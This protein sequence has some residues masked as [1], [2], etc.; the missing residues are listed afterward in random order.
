MNDNG[1]GYAYEHC[2]RRGRNASVMLSRSTTGVLAAIAL[3]WSCG[4]SDLKAG[5]T[6][7]Q[8][9]SGDVEKAWGLH[10]EDIA[11]RLSALRALRRPLNVSEAASLLDLVRRPQ[12]YNTLTPDARY[13]FFNEL[14]ETLRVAG[15]VDQV[16]L[17][18][19]LAETIRDKTRLE[20]ERDYALQHL[21]QLYELKTLPPEDLDVVFEM[22]ETAQS[23]LAATAVRTLGR[24]AAQKLPMDIDRLKKV[25]L[26][27]LKNSANR[28]QEVYAASIQVCVTL[29]LSEALPQIRQD[30]LDAT[31][32]PN[33]RL[34]ALYAL[35]ELGERGDQERLEQIKDTDSRCLLAL[36]MARKKLKEKY[37]L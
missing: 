10:G 29:R 18:N 28:G 32:P 36:S 13:L 6:P 25:A 30:A 9:S 24:V 20:I 11:T 14:L 33:V 3:C 34:V 8:S 4:V 23:A 5:I 7:E 1:R 19:G 16:A 2:L 37:Q 12:N 31:T 35:G 21:G 26:N 17:A 22:A 27:V 15:G